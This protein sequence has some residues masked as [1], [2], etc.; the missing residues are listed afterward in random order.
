MFKLSNKSIE[1]M[2]GVDERLIDI[3]HLAIKITKT[4][5]GIPQDGGFRNTQCQREL[6]EDGK[7]KADGVKYK[8]RHQ[9]GLALDFFAYVNGKASW[10][11]L[12]L[13]MVATAFLQAAS[14]LG[15]KVEWGGNFRSFKDMPHIQLKD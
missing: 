8:S 11:E 3:A 7:S 13:A 15:H 1:R 12:H 9:S 5:F 2:E 14:L 6:Y 10:N 4:D